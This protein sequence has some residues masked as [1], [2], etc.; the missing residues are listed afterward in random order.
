[1]SIHNICFCG[2][3]RKILIYFGLIKAS[4]QELW[5]KILQSLPVVC[6]APD[7]SISPDKVMNE[8][9]LVS[10]ASQNY[11]TDRGQYIEYQKVRF[12]AKIMILLLNNSLILTLILLFKTTP[13]FAN[14]VDPNQM[15]S[16][17]I[18]SG[19]TLFVIEFVNLKENIIWCNLIGW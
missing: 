2:E 3:I 19:S 7:K 17:A 11:V 5:Y 16:K 12:G 18:W 1:M 10:F 13:T 15:A 4:Y 9:S 14:S 6:I 8:A